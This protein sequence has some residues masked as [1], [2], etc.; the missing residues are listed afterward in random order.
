M[1]R[2]T[3]S[4]RAG[5]WASRRTRRADEALQAAQLAGD[6][7][8]IL[9]LVYDGYNGMGNTD[10][11]AEIRAKVDAIREANR[12]RAAEAEA[13]KAEAEAESEPEE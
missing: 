11:A 4:S 3:T 7:I 12:Q 2:I 10:R 5:C 6:D 9:G 8:Y 1:T 13:A